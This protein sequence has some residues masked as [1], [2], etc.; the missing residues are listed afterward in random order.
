[1]T[2]NE[3]VLWIMKEYDNITTLDAFK[4][5]IT[6]LSAR[7]Y[8][9]RKQGHKIKATRKAVKSRWGNTVVCEYKLLK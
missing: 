9:L 8:D 4:N 7:I 6:R 2:Q 3:S 5:G 1:M